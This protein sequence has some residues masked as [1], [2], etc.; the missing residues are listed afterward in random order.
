MWVERI[1][2]TFTSP[3]DQTVCGSFVG[4]NV[5]EVSKLG[6]SAGEPHLAAAFG[7]PLRD[8]AGEQEGIA[9][10]RDKFLGN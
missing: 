4:A 3:C 10:M 7:A 8:L 1:A 5:I 2:L 9:D 6:G